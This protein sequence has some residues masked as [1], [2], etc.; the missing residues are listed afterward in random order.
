MHLHNTLHR[1]PALAAFAL[2]EPIKP[3]GY[4]PSGRAVFPIAGGAPEDPPADPPPT[5][6]PAYTPPASQADLDRIVGERLA[7]E[8]AKYADYDDLKTK[9][10]AHD[11]ALEAAKSD[12]DKAVDAARTEGEKAATERVNSRLVKSEAR[13]LASAAKFRDPADAVAFLD[14]T[15]VTVN[16]DGEVDEKAIKEQLDALATSKPYLVDGGK[17]PAPKSDRSQGGGGGGDDKPSLARGREMFE[18]RRGKKTS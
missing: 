12:A 17:K 2:G 8:R 6:P 16:D 9:A 3:V 11:A 4:L 15:K 14:L 13:V 1:T 10:E 5:D 7:R 18:Q